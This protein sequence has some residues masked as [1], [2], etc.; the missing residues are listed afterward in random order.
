[1]RPALS[2]LRSRIG[3]RIFALF[4]VAASVP[5]LAMGVLSLGKVESVLGRER[6]ADLVQAGKVYGM[7]LLDRLIWLDELAA[8]VRD[9]PAGGA[10]KLGRLVTRVGKELAG[11]E[12]RDA[13]GATLLR[14]GTTHDVT[15]PA[16]ALARIAAGRPALVLAANDPPH[17]VYVS[18]LPGG[19]DE[20]GLLLAT[21]APDYLWGDADLQPAMTEF[22]VTTETGR[23]LHCAR[24]ALGVA[25]AK[26]VTLPTATGA[27]SVV[28]HDGGELQ[29]A[30]AWPLPMQVR[31]GTAD[32]I[33]TANQPESY[34]MRAAESFR[35][36]FIPIVALSLA[37][38]VLLSFEQIRRVL[39]PLQRL[40]A[41]TQAM[42]SQDFS[43]KVDVRTRDEFGQLAGSFNAMVATLGLHFRTL[44]ALSEIDRM[45]LTDLDL[46]NVAASA[47]RCVRRIST[48]DV[49]SFGLF[50][51]EAPDTMRVYY[52]WRD[53]K[54]GIRRADV[55]CS[56]AALPLGRDEA[57]DWTR[58]PPLPQAYLSRIGAKENSAYWIRPIARGDRLW[59]VF[60]LAMHDPK[61]LG[62]EQVSLLMSIV[63]RLAVAVASAE[64]DRKLYLQAHL[65]VLTGLPNRHYLLALL[66]QEL[67]HA[68]REKHRVGLLFLDL[69]RFK[70]TNDTLGHAAG[71][72]LLRRAAERI[73]GA[74]RDSDTVARLGGDEFTIVLTGLSSARE[75]GAVAQQL[76]KALADPL[77]VEGQKIHAGASIG[78]AM[79]PDDGMTSTELLK[80]ADT[81]MYRAKEQGRGGF[82]F[83]EESMNVDA[84]RRATLD[85]E[86][87]RALERG[88]L[89]LHYQ[90]QVDLRTGQVCS[91]EALV[92]WQHPQ[93]GLLA[94]GDFIQ[95]A[96]ES[97]LI[98]PIGA[99]V[100]EEACAQHARWRRAGV[101]VPRVAVNV[102]NR[103]LRRKDFLHSVDSALVN[104]GTPADGLE[105]EVTESLFLEGGEL[106]VDA[107]RRLEQAGVRVAID[108]FGTGYSSLGYLKTL[109]ASILKLDRS[110]IVGADTDRD[111]GAIVA[112]IVSMAHTLRKE[113]VAEGVEHA[114]QA[115]FLGRLGCHRIQ[116]YLISRPLP[117][118]AFAAFVRQRTLVPPGG[119]AWSPAALTEDDL[120]VHG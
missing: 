26:L 53:D 86:L 36:A 38:V 24:P 57:H 55:R 58:T 112:A 106:A 51:V 60:A 64:R 91:A 115:E 101:V 71:D 114:A 25:A 103:Q 90:P 34:A 44:K 10:A 111:A 27:R 75:A 39:F 28:L 82:V 23:S 46:R 32:W 54:A 18:R 109:P 99:W 4:F 67:A 1:M 84:N 3:R 87:R 83:F 80:K 61:P 22:C 33:V 116:G 30:G 93:R 107:L 105:V 15:L 92:R 7:S 89:V 88:E 85:R 52:L 19:G 117:A 6:D 31:F 72:E 11:V 37:I 119:A 5:I 113:I 63:D 35:S 56:A 2:L 73:K 100:I 43:A 65:D 70:Q 62:R 96:E 50:D 8:E 41:G 78:I 12:A 59:G 110:F 81:A 21:I 108:D 94:P 97:G 17:V 49:V 120:V 48:A 16:D 69:D 95:F 76:L 13:A 77:D 40:L 20:P 102:S 104:S 47:L 14:A 74:V 42:A 29:R 79:F 98:D 45:I 118:D 68:R 66:D 9:D